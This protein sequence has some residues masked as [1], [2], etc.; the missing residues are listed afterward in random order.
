[1]SNKH[2]TGILLLVTAT[3]KEELRLTID[4]IGLNDVH[5]YALIDS[6]GGRASSPRETSFPG[7]K[8]SS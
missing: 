8:T 1:M 2:G 6:F 7:L 4:I 5:V 3:K